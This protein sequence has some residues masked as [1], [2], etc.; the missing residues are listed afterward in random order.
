MRDQVRRA[1]GSVSSNIAEGFERSSRAE[2]RQFLSIAKG[3]CRELRSQLHLALRLGYVTAEAH[4]RCV[5]ESNE[6]SRKIG[7]LRASIVVRPGVR[8]SA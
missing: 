3:S 1:A 2:L 6:V 7:K 8:R 5:K 4:E